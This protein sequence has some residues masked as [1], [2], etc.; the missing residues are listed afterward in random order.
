M[1]EARG[2]GDIAQHAVESVDQIAGD[3]RRLGQ[4][5]QAFATKPGLASRT[6]Q[7]TPAAR[8]TAPVRHGTVISMHED[9]NDVAGALAA[10]RGD[11]GDDG[12]V[13]VPNALFDDA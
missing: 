13:G 4:I 11:G 9:R 10:E 12:D 3:S 2:C 6:R 5:L 8:E 7:R 1:R